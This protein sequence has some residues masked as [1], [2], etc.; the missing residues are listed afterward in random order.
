LSE[1]DNEMAIETT[2]T[3]ERVEYQR[4][5]VCRDGLAVV[6]WDEPVGGGDRSLW[7]RDCGYCGW[8][9]AFQNGPGTGE[10]IVDW[11]AWTLEDGER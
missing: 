1:G 10:W 3:V 7:Q 2:E 9:E 6:M 11:A 8:Y 5:G 4:C